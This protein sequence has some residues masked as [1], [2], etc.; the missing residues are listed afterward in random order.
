MAP[1]EWLAEQVKSACSF[2]IKYLV[3]HLPGQPVSPLMA[4]RA[5]QLAANNFSAPQ[6]FFRTCFLG[7]LQA[8]HGE[9]E[10]DH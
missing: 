5:T 1:S 9:Q 10:K 8:T 3:S 7:N 6:T 2:E 4:C